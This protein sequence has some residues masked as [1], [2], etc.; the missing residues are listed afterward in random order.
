[1][2]D[3]IIQCHR[4]IKPHTIGWVPGPPAAYFAAF[5][6]LWRTRGPSHLPL[7]LPF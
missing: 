2:G 3:L 6:G 5:A 1:M 7:P 4:C